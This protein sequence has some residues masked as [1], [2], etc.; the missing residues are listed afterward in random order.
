MKKDI[1]KVLV[2]LVFPVAFNLLFF[3]IGGTERTAAEWISYGFIHFAYL[4][5]ILTPV[6]CKKGKG[7]AVLN[8]SLYLRALAYFVVELIAGVAFL[9]W[10]PEET[11]WPATVQAV[12][13]AAFLLMQLMS[14]AANEATD[15]SL[16]RQSR[17]KIY[18]QDLASNVREAMQRVQDPET[19]K[20]LR[21]VYEELKSA[22]TGSCPEAEEIELQLAANVNALCMDAQSS[23]PSQIDSAIMAAR[24]T[25]RKRN[26]II[27][28]N[29]LS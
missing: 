23:S 11:V 8:D 22:S 18:I 9:L 20:K 2:G 13:A 6:F 15:E 12:I 4:C 1:F 10:N 19:R 7:R 3:L 25:L 29:L 16:A 26:S 21:S 24:E 28:R 5:I 27:N 14:V 17:E